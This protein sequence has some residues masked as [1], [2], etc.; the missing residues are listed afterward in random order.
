[1]KGTLADF[2]FQINEGVIQGDDGKRYSFFGSEW[3]DQTS[4]ARGQYVDFS[5]NDLY[6]KFMFKFLLERY[7]AWRKVQKLKSLHQ[8][9]TSILSTQR[10]AMSLSVVV[11][12]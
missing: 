2:N 9:V 12:V 7:M 6:R 11:L 3:K 10:N 5:V 1:M 8:Q 4:P